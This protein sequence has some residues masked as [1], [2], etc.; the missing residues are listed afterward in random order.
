MTGAVEVRGVTG[1]VGV[2]GAG[3]VRVAA[4]GGT[5]VF[6]AGVVPAG[7]TGLMLIRGIR[8]FLVGM[9]EGRTGPVGM[10]FWLAPGPSAAGA[11]AGRASAA[12]TAMAARGIP[13]RAPVR[14]KHGPGIE[15]IMLVGRARVPH[16]VLDGQ[17]RVAQQKLGR[18]LGVEHADARRVGTRELVVGGCDGLEEVLALLLEAVG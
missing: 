3:E 2:A 9:L 15:Q 7:A 4:A 18:E 13:A 16:Q 1:A 14:M 10:P 11:P 6:G 17:H 12:T 8:I 5:L